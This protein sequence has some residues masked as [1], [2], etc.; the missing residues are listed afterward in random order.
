M[1]SKIMMV[2]LCLTMSMLILGTDLDA[3]ISERE[4]GHLQRILSRGCGA[5]LVIDGQ[6]GPQTSR[7]YLNA[8]QNLG[9]E[10]TDESESSEEIHA[11]CEQIEIRK[12]ALVL[13]HQFG[14][15]RH[16][17]HILSEADLVQALEDV[18]NRT[19]IEPRLELSSRG[20]D[21]L[22][23]WY[24]QN[25]EP[26]TL[27]ARPRTLGI[28]AL[29]GAMDREDLLAADPDLSFETFEAFSDWVIQG[30]EEDALHGS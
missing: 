5:S 10:V 11:F 1:G 9:F 18:K 29:W 6:W 8:R 30:G 24:F 16:Q 7:A 21:R 26:A 28:A 12:R 19:D 25:S 4:I 23:R 22:T 17:N 27:A 3:Q 15:F 13:L 2:G 20:L 14:Y